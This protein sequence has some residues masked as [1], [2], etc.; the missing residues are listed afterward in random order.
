MTAFT[1]P[2][3][4]SVTQ[5]DRTHVSLELEPYGSVFVLFGE[6]LEYQ[7]AKET[8]E[9]LIPIPGPWT[10]A[11]SVSKKDFTCSQH[12]EVT[13]AVRKGSNNQKICCTGPLINEA[14]DPQNEPLYRMET[15]TDDRP[16]FNEIINQIRRRRISLERERGAVSE[17]RNAGLKGAVRVVVL[18]D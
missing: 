3:L 16:Y 18:S 7:T 12:R 9:Q 8:E 1:H 4:S 15:L 14:I 2:V 11:V 6:G 17:P 10:L 13:E 5:E